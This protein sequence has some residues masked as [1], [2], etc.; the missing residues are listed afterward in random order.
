MLMHASSSKRLWGTEP[1]PRS[2]SVA[3]M[4]AG[5]TKWRSAR[6]S[7]ASVGYRVVSMAGYLQPLDSHPLCEQ[8]EKCADVG[9]NVI[10]LPGFRQENDRMKVFGRTDRVRR[11][12]PMLAGGRS[13]A[14]PPLIP[15]SLAQMWAHAGHR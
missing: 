15:H 1:S 12:L 5:G 6:R 3:R 9:P 10:G 13:S 4:V 7:S 14:K 11:T 8:G 2:S